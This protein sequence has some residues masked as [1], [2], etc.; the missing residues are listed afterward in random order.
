MIIDLKKHIH[1]YV[2]EYCVMIMMRKLDIDLL[3]HYPKK[4]KRIPFWYCK[5]S[6]KFKITT[7]EIPLTNFFHAEHE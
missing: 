2:N 3:R 4:S 6:H 5:T 7:T 1:I